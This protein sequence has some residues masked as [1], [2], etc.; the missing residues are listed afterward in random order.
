MLCLSFSFIFNSD[1]FFGA[2]ILVYACSM[3]LFTYDITIQ[4][5]I[6]LAFFGVS[7][8]RVVGGFDFYTNIIRRDGSSI[9]FFLFVWMVWVYSVGTDLFNFSMSCIY[10]QREWGCKSG[11]IK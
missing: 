11:L 8:V 6:Y 7:G 9:S 10:G 2:I 1:S 3:L 5:A 4:H